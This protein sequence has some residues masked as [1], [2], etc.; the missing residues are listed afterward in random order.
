MIKK[1]EHPANARMDIDYTSGKPNVKFTYPSKNGKK[2]ALKE[3]SF[4]YHT[5]VLILLIWMI[6]YSFFVLSFGTFYYKEYPT[7]CNVTLNEGYANVTIIIDG[8]EDNKNVNLSTNVYKEFVKGADFICDNGNYSVYFKNDYSII[9]KDTGFEN[10][11][12]TNYINILCFI[13]YFFLFAPV[14]IYLLNKKITKILLNSKRYC[15]WFP[16]AQ[17]NGVLFKKKDKKYRKFNPNDVLENVIIIPRFSNVELDYKTKGD[18]SKYLTKI[19]IR[20]YKNQKINI[21]SNKKTKIKQDNYKWYAIFYFKQKPKT[22]YL[23]VIF[24]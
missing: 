21:K 15:N 20:E 6:P 14:L 3:H 11:P 19:K 10:K 7:D 18:F 1:G 2:Q 8:F 4:W 24:Q 16:K 22:G 23:E 12:E 13:F 17:A 9:H 5:M